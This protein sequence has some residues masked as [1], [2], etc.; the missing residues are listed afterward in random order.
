MQKERHIE[1]FASRT[2]AIVS[3]I[4]SV[5]I[6]VLLRGSPERIVLVRFESI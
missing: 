5:L 2:K 3:F 4:I 6:V 1:S